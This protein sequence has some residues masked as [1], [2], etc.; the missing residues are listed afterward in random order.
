MSETLSGALSGT[1][2][3]MLEGSIAGNIKLLGAQPVIESKSITEN[4]TYTAPEGVD[5]YSP[6]TVNVP[7]P[8]PVIQSKSITENGTYTAPE[9]VDGYSPVTVNVPQRPEPVIQSKSITENGTYT[10]PEGVDGYS[11][12]TVNVAN[13]YIFLP[14]TPTTMAIYKESSM[15]FSQNLVNDTFETIWN[16]G[17]M[18]GFTMMGQYNLRGFNSIDIDVQNIGTSY[19]TADRFQ[20]NVGILNQIMNTFV[21]L[22]YNTSSTMIDYVIV[23]SSD[24]Y[25]QSFHDTIEIPDNTD[26][27]LYISACGVNAQ[28]IKVT[29]K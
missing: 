13:S 12:I 2:S 16:G 8:T 11:P 17:S 18:V 22:N 23:P 25:M 14:S 20:F 26:C 29:I 4:G 28:G 6:I 10:A 27:Y 5:G 19:S 3:E 7:I 21:L 15:A 24:Y 1:I 9:G